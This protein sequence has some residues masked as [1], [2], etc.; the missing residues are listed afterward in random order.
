MVYS[1]TSTPRVKEQD[2]LNL[3]WLPQ[4]QGVA[5]YRC[6]RSTADGQGNRVARGTDDSGAPAGSV[7]AGRQTKGGPG[8]ILLRGLGTCM[9]SNSEYVKRPETDYI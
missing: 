9:Y 7:D 5:A 6:I 8:A 2:K 3:H 4:G 1:P